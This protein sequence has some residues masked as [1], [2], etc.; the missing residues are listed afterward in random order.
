MSVDY[1]FQMSE[2]TSTNNDL[3]YHSQF[4]EH[5]QLLMKVVDAYIYCILYITNVLL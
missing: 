4:L 1:M 5:E 3:T 2:I